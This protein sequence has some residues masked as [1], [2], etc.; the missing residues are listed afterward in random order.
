MSIL[1]LPSKRVDCRYL[2]AVGQHYNSLDFEL[3]AQD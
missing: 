1:H 2:M 3:G